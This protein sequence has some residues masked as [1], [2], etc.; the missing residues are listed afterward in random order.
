MRLHFATAMSNGDNN[1]DSDTNTQ[2]HSNRKWRSS[3]RRSGNG[4]KIGTSWRFGKRRKKK[5]SSRRASV[6]CPPGPIGPPGI[7]GTK[8]EHFNTFSV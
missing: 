2:E 6:V 5:E 7:S 3:K 4:D 8:G 1:D